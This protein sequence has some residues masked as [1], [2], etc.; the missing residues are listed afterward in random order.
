MVNKLFKKLLWSVFEPAPLR[1][2]RRVLEAKGRRF[3][4]SQQL[5]KTAAILAGI[6][7][8]CATAMLGLE[9]IDA[10]VWQTIMF[11][12][13]GAGTVGAI[14]KNIALRR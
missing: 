7:V 2:W 11:V 14:G 8:V 1:K 6:A 4:M 12:A 3:N 9:R 10:G 13:L 5:S